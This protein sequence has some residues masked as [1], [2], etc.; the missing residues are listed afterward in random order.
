MLPEVG[1]TL[2][3]MIG[4]QFDPTQCIGVGNTWRRFCDARTDVRRIAIIFLGENGLPHAASWLRW[5]LSAD[6]ETRRCIGLFV[7]HKAD[8]LN[9]G[10]E[11]LM[12][13]YRVHLPTELCRLDIDPKVMFQ[14]FRYCVQNVR[15]YNP[16]CYSHFIL[17]TSHTAPVKP[18][19]AFVQEGALDANV[20]YL[21]EL[22]HRSVVSDVTATA[23]TYAMPILSESGARA[24]V[25]ASEQLIATTCDRMLSTGHTTSTA[26]RACM[27]LL[28]AA[29]ASKEFS[30]RA[31]VFGE[32]SSLYGKFDCSVLTPLSETPTCLAHDLVLLANN[33]TTLV[34]DLRLTVSAQE[35]YNCIDPWSLSTSFGSVYIPNDQAHRVHQQQTNLTAI[36]DRR[37]AQTS[38]VISGL[39]E[40]LRP[41]LSTSSMKNTRTIITQL[42]ITPEC[43]RLHLVTLQRIRRGSFLMEIDADASERADMFRVPKVGELAN[44][45]AVRFDVGGSERICLFARSDI[46]PS[47]SISLFPSEMESAREFT[48][49]I[50]SSV[51][52][53]DR[54]DEDDD[55]VEHESASSEEVFP[56]T[57]DAMSS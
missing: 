32:Y 38:F 40:H 39:T 16:D 47:S 41:F 5:L 26:A 1:A 22:P 15:T 55:D 2:D 48:A 28:D 12:R 23:S 25:D 50:P 9:S 52:V 34:V 14:A 4:A 35:D 10:V 54:T 57:A 19:S 7:W 17:A 27:S 24:I 42:R 56:R 53:G 8:V 45:V 6:D 43:R 33:P 18:P 46:S 30:N 29:H 51:P 13:P 31:V 21:F 3:T 36:H 37:T 44:A 20:S 49:L 11:D